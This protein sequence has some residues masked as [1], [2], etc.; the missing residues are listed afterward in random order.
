[1]AKPFPYGRMDARYCFSRMTTLPIPTRCRSSMTAARSAYACVAA[2]SRGAR[3]Y[4]SRSFFPPREAFKRREYFYAGVM[5]RAPR[6]TGL[7]GALDELYGVDPSE[8]VA[9][10]KRLATDLRASGEV[11]AAKELASARRPTNAAWALNQLVRRHPML[12]ERFLLRS[13]ELQQAQD[14]ALSGKPDEL[15]D[16]TRSQRQAM[17][18]ATQAAMAVLGDD[19]TEAYRTQIAATLQA[20]SVD[21]ETAGGLQQGRLTREVTGSTGFPDAG[22][23]SIAKPARSPKSKGASPARPN[24]AGKPETQASR[25]RRARAEAELASAESSLRTAKDAITS[26]EKSAEAAN[27]RVDNLRDELDTAR[28][29]ARAAAEA[30]QDA[31]RA[32]KQHAKTVDGLRVQKGSLDADS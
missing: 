24:H 11:D 20:A 31:R 18:A 28:Q 2:S 25:A 1:M 10:R 19:A 21:E 4:G 23:L 29:E 30:V 26:A 16:A 27:A 8:F 17:A 15:R 5:A 12:V 22:P 7:E 9:T 32:V 13:R 6:Q 14:R 3:W